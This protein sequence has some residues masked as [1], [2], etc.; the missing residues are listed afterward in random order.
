MDINWSNLKTADGYAT[1]FPSYI[2]ALCSESE[3]ER[4]IAYWKIDNHAVLQGD[5]YQAAYYIIDPLVNIVKEC[6]YR[7]Q[8]LNLLIEI[9]LGYGLDS[10]LI[11]LNGQEI[12][13]MNACREKFI[14]L[15]NFFYDLRDDSEFSNDRELLEELIEIIEEF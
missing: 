1:N 5:L 8:A 6:P 11:I 13:V 12:S 14:S 10:D 9:S 15:K 4:D 3:A 2:K 7:K